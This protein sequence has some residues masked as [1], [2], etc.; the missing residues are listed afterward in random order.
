MPQ[1]ALRDAQNKPIPF[2][3]N[4]MAKYTIQGLQGDSAVKPRQQSSSDTSLEGQ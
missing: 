3:S 1:K 2:P 4:V